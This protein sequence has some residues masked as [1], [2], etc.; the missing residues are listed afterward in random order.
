[1]E[2]YQSPKGAEPCW[3]TCQAEVNVRYVQCGRI[4]VSPSTTECGAAPLLLHPA[5]A[6]VPQLPS[7]LDLAITLLS[8]CVAV[9]SAL[10]LLL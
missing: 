2:D 5:P 7:C 9:I 6:C 4:I 8:T 1:M 10:L 3:T